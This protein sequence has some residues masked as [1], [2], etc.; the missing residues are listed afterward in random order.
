MEYCQE[1]GIIFNGIAPLATPDWVTFTE[2]GMTKTTLEEPGVKKMATSYGK[3]PAQIIQ[4]WI[5]QQNIAI[6]TRSMNKT[7]MAENL[8]VFDWELKDEDIQ[9]LNS[10]P[11][12]KTQRGN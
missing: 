9:T 12:C 6:Q 4:R 10:Y 1:K 3:S 7:H 11:Q 8:D 5:I 2:D